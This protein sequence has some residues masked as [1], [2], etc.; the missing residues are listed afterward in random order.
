MGEVR[1]RVGLSGGVKS[2]PALAPR[3]SQ[4]IVTLAGA[5]TVAL[6]SCASA[7]AFLHR[8]HAFA[9]SFETS[10][11]NKLSEPTAVAVNE[12]TGDTYVLDKGNDRVVRFG[13]KHEFLE[14]WGVGVGG[15][16][17]YER[18]KV[19][20]Q[21]KSGV[22]GASSPTKV[23]F[24]EPVAIAVDNS[25]SSLS[26][27]DVYVVANRT[28]KK[29]IVYKF[30]AQGEFVWSLVRKAEEKEE[31]WP[32][33]GVV[34]DGTGTVWIDREDEEEEFVIERFNSAEH[35]AM[36]GEPE[37]YE[38]PEVVKFR[39]PVRPGF[40][41][42]ALGRV[43]V[44]YEPGGREIEEE[45]ELIKE[46]AE[47]R[48]EKK[49]AKIEEHLVEPCTERRCEVARFGPGTE[50]A[51]INEEAEIASFNPEAN[52]TG[53]A[54]DTTTGRQSSGDVYL[55]D[56]ASLAAFTA[57]QTPIQDFGAG[58]L[59]AGGGAGLGVDGATNEVLVADRAGSKIDVYAPEPIGPP[60]I[61]AGSLATADVGV[62]SATAKA[63][64]D[65]TGADTHY[66]FRYGAEPCSGGASACAAIAPAL[67]GGDLGAGFGD[68]SASAG[69]SGLAPETT[70]HFVVVAVSEPAGKRV[71]IVSSEEATFKTLPANRLE[72]VLPDGR[73]WELVSPSDKRGAAVEPLSHEG[74]LI[75]AAANGRALTFIAAAPVGEEEPSGNRAPETSQL[76]STRGS[77]GS[78]VTHNLTTPN[79]SAVGIKANTRREYQFFSSDLTL[80]ALFPPEAL[81]PAQTTATVSGLP[82]Y[83]REPGCTGAPC[84]TPLAGTSSEPGHSSFEAATANLGHIGVNTGS[85][86]VEWSAEEAQPGEGHIRPVSVLPGGAPAT[87]ATGF[88]YQGLEA[89]QGSR[90]AISEDGKRAAWVQQLPSIVHL[91][92]TEFQQGKAESIQVDVQNNEPGL[93]PSTIRP[94]PVYET[95]SVNGDRLFFTDDQRLTANA[96][97]GTNA[98]SRLPEENEEAGDL[99]VFERGKEAGKR[100]TDLTPDL[101]SGESS[102]VLAA[103]AGASEDGSYVYFVANGVLAPGA[104]PGHCSRTGLPSAKCNL[105]EAHNNG[106]EWEAP[107]L[108]A[109]LSNEDLPDT[110][111][112]AAVREEQY[113]V[114]ELTAQVSPSGQFLAFMSDQRLTGYD[115]DDANS[116]QPDEEVFLFN[117]KTGKL[118]CASCN[119]T[120]AQPI[121]VHD[122]EESGEGRGLFVDRLGIWS[123]ETE[124]TP[125]DHW[126][127]ASVPGWTNLDDRESFYQSRYLSNSGRLFFNAADSLVKQDVNKGKEDVYEYEPTGIGGCAN[128]NTTEGC[129]SLI[130]SGQSEHESTFLDASENGNDV[131]FLTS[132]RLIPSLDT[133]TAFD[134]YDARVCSG[135]EAEEATCPPTALP[136]EEPCAGEECRPAP[137]SHRPL[138]DAPTLGSATSSSSGNVSQQQVLA[139]KQTS[140]AKPKP[141]TRAQKLAAALKTCKKKYKS[142]RKKRIACERTARHKYAAK[143]AAKRP[144]AGRSKAAG[145]R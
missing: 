138:G 23:G 95:S 83:L 141:L 65:P 115:N 28:W 20:A 4:I 130:S 53:I 66:Y 90:H 75:Q 73:A 85:G 104:V 10:G 70:Y 13:P 132:A 7:S 86:L 135:P 46:R 127:A 17:E 39:H 22:A 112:V 122:V 57:G 143:K 106:S 91:F 6:L 125:S 102:A 136:P 60:V 88:G 45:E 87:G 119:P 26:K 123:A 41:V 69:L 99:Y 79:A 124:E 116:G 55:D 140:S 27:G 96:S 51:S 139:S 121:G 62:E 100:L 33:D 21:C 36:I 93:A 19:E 14:A 137:T 64:I 31:H 24:D 1:E 16:S 49:E 35:N 38:L 8:G 109:R 76:I 111:A 56:G 97:F 78:W 11:S 77:A 81:E 25:S 3:R 63:T 84:Y 72:S 89:F 103:V 105:Y 80:A 48:R 108:I 107:K 98:L 9:G 58:E 117:A 30:T 37:E 50:G 12:S 32:I 40:A 68:Q 128:D 142:K 42:D 120:G 15:G 126:L 110:G 67:P 2:Q 145:R 114:D 133:D 131:F 129:V 118:V 101:N 82:I 144:A 47:E 5:L 43:Y 71:E 74:G 29:A 52:T 113:K 59:A 134:I 18:C 92:Q 94:D 34:V 61:Q 54:L 44:T